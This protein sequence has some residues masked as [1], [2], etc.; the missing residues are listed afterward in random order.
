LASNL[1]LVKRV[2]SIAKE[3]G[4]DIASPAEARKILGFH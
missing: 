1:E 4:R 3:L 2:V